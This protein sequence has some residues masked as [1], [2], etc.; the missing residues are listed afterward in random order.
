MKTLL[1]PLDERPCNYMFP[2]M[3]GA[4]N[5]EICI[6]APDKA[7]LGDKKTAADA[8]KLRQF[9]MDNA[10]GCTNA[11]L[12]MD[13]LVYG[14]LIP[15]RLHHLS[16]EEALSRLD[17]LREMKS[18]NPGIKIYVFD[19]IMR[20]PQYNSSDEEPDY[21][22]DYGYSLFRRKYLLDYRE[23]HDSLAD[24]QLAE[25]D[26]IKIPQE[27]IDDYEKRR[28]F[29]EFVNIEVVNC[30][31]KGYVDFLVI[32]QDDSSPYGY[33]AISQKNV[34]REIKNKNLDLKIMIYPGADE[35][36]LSLLARAWNDH[37]GIEPKVFP[38]YASVLGPTIVPLFEDRPM[39]ESL[40][41]HLRVCGAKLAHSP[42][43]AD[44]VLAV[45]S[46]GKFMQDTYDTEFDVSYTSFRNLP[47]FAM[48]IKEHI[49]AGRPVAVCDSA[50]CNGGDIQFIHY[51]DRLDV[52]DRLLSYAGWNTNCNTLGTTLA[53]ACIG[54]RTQEDASGVL[55]NLLYR[56]IEDACYQGVVRHDVSAVDLPK[57][58]L[59]SSD[60][61]PELSKVELVIREKLQKY[62]ETLNLS[63]KHGVNINSIFSP[64]KRMF[65]IGMEISGNTF[66]W[67]K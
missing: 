25:L 48:Q 27:F 31:E 67:K 20:T 66:A 2:Q 45:N 9:L 30:L 1:L 42:Q 26:A 54:G 35:V 3:I 43:E 44:F 36:A 22:A 57:M 39:F 18:A 51:L 59:D 60:I 13:M 50:Y 19:C 28:L 49:D 23:R 41:S 40:K 52:L 34:M 47:D 46:P 32:P 53:Q 8:G 11:V 61:T 21:Y 6:I 62:Y 29:N 65:E 12:S 38:F 5:R 15:S 55:H 10:A 37:K 33:T 58:N 7:I 64:W 16:K 14:G 24:E 63:K 4:S 17:V 56:I